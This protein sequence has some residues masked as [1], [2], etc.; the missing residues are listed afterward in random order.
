MIVV[1]T[2]SS[3]V[4]IPTQLRT[5][6]MDYIPGTRLYSTIINKKLFKKIYKNKNY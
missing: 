4:T 6:S 2:Q 5:D 3:T 1:A